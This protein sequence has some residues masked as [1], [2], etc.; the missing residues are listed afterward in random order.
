MSIAEIIGRRISLR[1]VG[2][3]HVGYCPF[4]EGVATTFVVSD[5]KGFF[6][7]FTCEAHGDAVGFVM[8]SDNLTFPEAVEKVALE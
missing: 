3:H 5:E 2:V 4:C 7:C 8:H 6:H 1:K